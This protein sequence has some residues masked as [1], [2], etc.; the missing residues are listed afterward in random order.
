MMF[1]VVAFSVVLLLCFHKTLGVRMS[2]DNGNFDASWSYSRD[3]DE[4]YFEVNAKTSGW[5]GFGFT[6]TPENMSNYDVV[7]G[8]Q[9]EWGQSYFY[10]SV[11]SSFFFLKFLDYKDS[12]CAQKF[13][14]L[15]KCATLR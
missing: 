7:I 6:F 9:T 2:F 13:R 11:V 1:K 4:L 10:V 15:K 3:F 8:G 14:K 5:V 12:K